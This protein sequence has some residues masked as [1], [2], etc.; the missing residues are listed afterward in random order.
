M[1]LVF[2]VEPGTSVKLKEF[3]PEHD[4]GLKKSQGEQRL[5]DLTAEL[6]E[7]QGLLSAAATHSVLVIL[8]GMDTSGKDG[9]IRGVFRDTN[10]QGLR[11]ESFKVPSVEEQAHDF[12][13][14]V[15]QKT[16]PRGTLMVFNRSH[17]EDVLVARVHNL[18]PEERI[19]QRYDQINNFERL[20]AQN[21]TIILKFFLY[22]SKEEQERRLLAREQDVTKAWKLSVGDW[23]ERVY[24]DDY[25]RAYA[26]AL[27]KCSTRFA[28]WHIVPSNRKWFRNLGIADT[29]V[30]ALRPYKRQ[31]LAKLQRQSES[32]LADIKA[33]RDRRKS[34]GEQSS[35]EQPSDEQS[36]T[37][38]DIPPPDVNEQP[39]DE[40]SAV[41]AD[42]P[43]P[44]AN[45]QA[46]E[47]P[48]NEAIASP[49]L[50]EAAP[51]PAGSEKNEDDASPPV[52]EDVSTPQP[53]TPAATEQPPTPEAEPATGIAAHPVD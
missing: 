28:P 22:I 24:W 13:W 5:K 30:T 31:W 50:P 7:L 14:R 47:P 16:P 18:A 8:Q 52:P 39:P 53:E 46:P 33:M 10:A 12:L 36:P 41:Q 23:K 42:A 32:A 25:Q 15:H 4:G 21:D 20:L 44:D 37:P 49:P 2:T 48:T 19:A 17:Y 40:Q 6:G 3:D 1:P 26:T 11:I 45:E 27:S 9:T 34:K 29:L 51:V 38:A 43:L 35:D